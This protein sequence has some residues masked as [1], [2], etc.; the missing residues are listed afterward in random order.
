MAAIQVAFSVNGQPV[1]PAQFARFEGN[2]GGQQF[3]QFQY[4]AVSQWPS[5]LTTLAT[6]VTFTQAINDGTADYP[7]GTHIYLYEV[8]KP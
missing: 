2:T 7:A 4:A 3:C 5:G 8:S 1:D 6:Q